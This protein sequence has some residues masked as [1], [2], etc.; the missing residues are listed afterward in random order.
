MRAIAGKRI[1]TGQ[2]SS[3]RRKWDRLLALLLAAIVL[4]PSVAMAVGKSDGALD[5]RLVAAQGRTGV[6]R[7]VA[8]R[9]Y[10]SGPADDAKV[11]SVA[12]GFELKFVGSIPAPG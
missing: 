2:E 6:L 3:W 12:T 9:Y 5:L 7:Y 10:I 1:V 4:V 11:E 8:D